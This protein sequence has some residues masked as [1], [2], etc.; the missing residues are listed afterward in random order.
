MDFVLKS[1]DVADPAITQLLGLMSGTEGGGFFTPDPE[2]GGEREAAQG[3]WS[4]T[5]GYN[6]EFFKAMVEHGF[7]LGVAW[8]GS[9]DT[10]HFELVEGRRLATSGGSRPLVAGTHT[11]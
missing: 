9:A 5:H 7:E 1:R 2:Q 4:G 6:L 3:K 8:D 10:M 11:H